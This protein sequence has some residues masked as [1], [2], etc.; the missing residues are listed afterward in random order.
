M[1]R[2]P[3]HPISDDR[4]R[5]SGCS[6]E[7]GQ[8]SC[9]GGGTDQRLLHAI[10]RVCYLQP[11]T[12][13]LEKEGPGFDLPMALS[14]VAGRER[15]PMEMLRE[16]SVVGELAL[17][18]EL[19]PV[20]GLLATALEARA[21]GRKR[22][23]VPKRSAVEASVV[24]GIEII[25]LQNLREAVEYL[26]GDKVIDPEPCRAA[27]FSSARHLRHRLQRSQRPAGRQ[28]CHRGGRCGRNIIC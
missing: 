18:G 11:R 15:L 13:R 25:G 21:K 20:R 8:G 10:E 5:S 19:R 1:P 28:A 24:K 7:R 14:L 26:R 12:R 4:S 27:E 2:I 3:R 17:D 9:D 23:L 16:C 6:S 22:L